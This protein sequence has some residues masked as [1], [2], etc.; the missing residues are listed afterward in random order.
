MRRGAGDGG[1]Y[2]LPSPSHIQSQV[3]RL[4]PSFQTFEFID[5]EGN[6][7]SVDDWGAPVDKFSVLLE[8]P[9]Y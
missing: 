3:L 2:V 5:V 9:F 4:P 1:C 6:D 7:M 8:E